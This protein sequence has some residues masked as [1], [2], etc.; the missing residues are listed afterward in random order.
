MVETHIASQAFQQVLDNSLKQKVSLSISCR[1]LKN[2][3]IM[4]KSDPQVHVFM[5]DTKS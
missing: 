3:D 1:K 2:L 4:S 5:K